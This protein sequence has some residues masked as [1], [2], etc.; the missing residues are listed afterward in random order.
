MTGK[1]FEIRLINDETVFNAKLAA[2]P[3]DI[4]ICKLVDYN[5][6]CVKEDRC[7]IDI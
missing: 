2:D 7:G 3:P 4:N 1:K 5:S 6:D